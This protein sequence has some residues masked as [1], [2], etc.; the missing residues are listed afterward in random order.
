[1]SKLILTEDA[2][3]LILKFSEKDTVDFL[4]YVARC[5]IIVVRG[6]LHQH[7]NLAWNKIGNTQVLHS[8]IGKK[9]SLISYIFKTIKEKY[10]LLYLMESNTFFAN[11]NVS[12]TFSIA[13]A[14]ICPAIL[15]DKTMLP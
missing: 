2:T 12:E 14:P 9:P 10:F 1:M 5:R 8:Q 6:R 4:V 15:N 3:I 13:F 7:W 11:E